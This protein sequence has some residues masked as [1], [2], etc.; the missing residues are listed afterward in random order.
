LAWTRITDPDQ[1]AEL[2][3]IWFCARMIGLRGSFGLLLT[4]G[5]VVLIISVTALPESS[6]GIILLDIAGV[7]EGVD[8]V[9]L[10]GA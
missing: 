2:L 1:A 7:P 5:D 6:S 8:Q 3:P 9:Y 4:S 10:P